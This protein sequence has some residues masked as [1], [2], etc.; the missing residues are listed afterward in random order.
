[1]ELYEMVDRVAATNCTV[2]ITGESG[3]GKELVARAVHETSPRRDRPFV[4]V[5]CGAIPE[6][7]LESELFGQVRGAFTGA[8]ATKLGRIAAAEGG[9]LF[10][11]EVGE[12]SPSLQMKLVRVIETHEYSPVGD[13]RTKKADL[14]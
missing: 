13:A 6:A 3:T 7:L 8:H 5:N 14:R 4:A 2:L 11:D 1:L 10:I 12:L 9:T